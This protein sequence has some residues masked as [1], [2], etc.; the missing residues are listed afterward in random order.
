MLGRREDL[1]TGVPAVYEPLAVGAAAVGFVLLPV[2]LSRTEFLVSGGPIRMLLTGIPTALVGTPGL[3]GDRFILSPHEATRF[4]AIR[5]GGV[6]AVLHAH[7]YV[8]H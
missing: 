6:D 7:H 2:E 3:D 5:S 4:K 8:A 1:C